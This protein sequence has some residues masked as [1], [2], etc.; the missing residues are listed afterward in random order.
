M[1]RPRVLLSLTNNPLIVLADAD[2]L[3]QAFAGLIDRCLELSPHDDVTVLARISAYEAAVEV[4]CRTRELEDA[5]VE[6]ARLLVPANG[7]RLVLITRGA[8]RGALVTV[9]LPL[10]LDPRKATG[11][12]GAPRTIEE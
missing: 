9:H 3:R 2:R 4:S 8:I 5:D 12:V 10:E 11:E 7:G 6:L 1:A